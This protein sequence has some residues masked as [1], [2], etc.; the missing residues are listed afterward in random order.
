MAFSN[1]ASSFV[2]LLVCRQKSAGDNIATGKL[3]VIVSDSRNF[4]VLGVRL[5]EQG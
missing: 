5:T 3:G 2:W 4:F 1:R